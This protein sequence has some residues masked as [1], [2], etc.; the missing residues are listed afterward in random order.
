MDVTYGTIWG[1]PL[2][3]LAEDLKPVHRLRNVYDRY[4]GQPKQEPYVVHQS[5]ILQSFS[6]FKAGDVVDDSELEKFFQLLKE[7]YTTYADNTDEEKFYTS[8]M[9]CGFKS[10]AGEAP[11]IM[12]QDSCCEYNDTSDDA[13]ILWNKEFPGISGRNLLFLYVSA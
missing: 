5:K 1:V 4:T 10:F 2:R 8:Y 6:S 7:K 11:Y 12:P 9:Y 3:E 13:K